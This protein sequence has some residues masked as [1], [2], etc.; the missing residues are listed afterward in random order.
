MGE[1]GMSQPPAGRDV[2]AEL[3]SLLGTETTGRLLESA[4]ITGMSLLTLISKSAEAY[5]TL[6]GHERNGYAIQLV[7]DT[8]VRSFRLDE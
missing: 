4:K 2:A 1:Q 5:A 7:R 3:R 8:E 6:A